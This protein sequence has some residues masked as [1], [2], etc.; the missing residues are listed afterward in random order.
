LS[1]PAG[2]Q[3]LGNH[4]RGFRNLTTGVRLGVAP[5]MGAAVLIPAFGVPL[6]LVDHALVFVLLVRAIRPAR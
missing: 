1:L 2:L 4:G 6:L 5:H 3:V